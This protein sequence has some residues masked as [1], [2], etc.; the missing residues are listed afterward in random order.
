MDEEKEF[1]LDENDGRKIQREFDLFYRNRLSSEVNR[2][3][4]EKIENY[5]F[6]PCTNKQSNEM[7][8]KHRN[9]MLEEANKLLL[10]YPQ[11]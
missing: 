6:Q 3:S 9:N 2:R 10:E 8:E 11:I 1:N 4:G 5:S 7:A